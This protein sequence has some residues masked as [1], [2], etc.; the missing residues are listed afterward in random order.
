MNS[1]VTPRSRMVVVEERPW[2]RY[3]LAGLLAG[4]GVVGLAVGFWLGSTGGQ[5]DTAVHR[6]LAEALEAARAQVVALERRVS[7]AELS[8]VVDLEATEQLR[9]TIKQMR[10]EQAAADEE[11]RFYRQL[12]APSEAEKGLRVEKLELTAGT[13]SDTVDYRLVL[14]QIVDRHEFIQGEVNVDFIGQNEGLQQVLSLTELTEVETYP[15]K[16]RFRYFQDFS[17]TLS[18]PDGF[19]P[20]RVV[21]TAAGKGRRAKQA[22]KTF[23]WTLQEG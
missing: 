1:K 9:Q 13:R 14:T 20:E 8:K 3:L 10:D 17:G 19:T 4:V 22:Q 12:M 21:V 15:L 11:L 7:D 6:E 18:L 23:S 5:V 16:F 2:Q